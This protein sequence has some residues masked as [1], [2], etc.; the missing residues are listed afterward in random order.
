MDYVWIEEEYQ[1]VL[2]NWQSDNM[3]WR[4]PFIQ[5]LVKMQL[6]AYSCVGY[7]DSFKFNNK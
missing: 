3:N 5:Y 1:R 4:N 2:M 7:A 6:K